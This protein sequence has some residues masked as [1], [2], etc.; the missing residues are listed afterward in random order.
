MTELE[1]QEGKLLNL[2]AALKGKEE[3]DNNTIKL[4]QDIIASVSRRMC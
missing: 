4:L 2:M 1:E 3:P